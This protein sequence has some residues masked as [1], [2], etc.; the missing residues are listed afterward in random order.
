MPNITNITGRLYENLTIPYW[1]FN[2]TCDWRAA[3]QVDL[4]FITIALI[5]NILMVLA[6]L[7]AKHEQ[8]SQS[9][10][11]SSYT[12]AASLVSLYM[13]SLDTRMIKS[14]KDYLDKEKHML[15]ILLW[16]MNYL[17][18]YHFHLLS[19][20]QHHSIIRYRG[21]H[22][23]TT[24]SKLKHIG[25]VVWFAAIAF[26]FLEAFFVFNLGDYQKV[27]DHQKATRLSKFR[28]VIILI[29][30]AFCWLGPLI[31]VISWNRT[32][33]SLLLRVV[34][35]GFKKIPRETEIDMEIHS[36]GTSNTIEEDNVEDGHTKKYKTK[37]NKY[38]HGFDEEE[39]EQEKEKE[40]ATLPDDIK[41]Q[42]SRSFLNLIVLTIYG[43]TFMMWLVYHALAIIR[44]SDILD[45]Y[46]LYDI[47]YMCELYISIN[48]ILKFQ[49]LLNP[50]WF[51]YYKNDLRAMNVRSHG[52]T[53]E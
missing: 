45:G 12:C 19:W 47:I 29:S 26:A 50:L 23:F 31:L 37:K 40:L 22:R 32:V 52:V 38:I 16:F 24:V 8:T 51:I 46:K 28:L 21:H 53:H 13:I 18:L 11:I 48:T 4:V 2:S 30:V 1:G 14:D 33:F 25:V 10:I 43:S 36:N 27:S 20:D 6:P 15:Y 44:T 9:K 42:L 34:H 41:K 39:E 5:Y 49:F 3:V 17:F 7:F 35:N